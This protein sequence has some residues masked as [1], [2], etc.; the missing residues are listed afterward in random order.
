MPRALRRSKASPHAVETA[1]SDGRRTGTFWTAFFF[2]ALLSTLWS[3]ASPVFSV[4]DENA[5]VIKAVG[6]L[7]GELVGHFDPDARHPV[8]DLPAGWSVSPQIQCFVYHPEVPASCG[9][10]IGDPDGATSPA[11]W[12]ARYNPLYYYVIG[13]PSLFVD[14][15][16]GVYILRILSALFGSVF[17]AWAYQTAV[18][19]ARARWMPFAVAFAASP[20][21][22]YLLGSV[23]PNGVEIASAV[24]L[25]TALPRLLQTFHP[26]SPAV[27][28]PR[29]YLWV[30]VVVACAVLAN[31]RALGP[32]W[33]VVVVLLC[34]LASGWSS[35]RGLFTNRRSYLWLTVIAVTGLFSV[36]WTLGGGS[37]SGQA[38]KADAPLVGA[39][40]PTGFV[41]MLR[42]T[43]PFLKQAVGYF[44]WFDASLPDVAFWPIVAAS[45]ILLVLAATASDRRS[46]LTLAAVSLSAILVPALVQAYGV[47]STGIIWQGRYGLFLYLGVAIVA[48]WLLSGPAG[49]RLA[50]LAP[51]VTWIGAGLILLYGAVAFALVLRRYVTGSEAL[52]SAMWNDPQW[53]PPLGW[54]AL[55]LLFGIVS[56][57][58]VLWVGLLGQSVARQEQS[59]A[60]EERAALAG[61]EK[62]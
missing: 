26:A 1:V 20:M 35:V 52:P 54:P 15:S 43:V 61:S 9:V 7:R 56:V 2:F 4:P 37:L 32:L 42:L 17:L 36:L 16:A 33:L 27:T 3:L 24:A 23:N 50:Y 19:G 12:V 44:G 34:F 48:G 31:A 29:W 5:H 39:S 18:A 13:W 49:D 57:G 40:F 11:S 8:F 45:A 58:F 51:R 47:A 25:W 46:V 38:E 53:Q 55:C 59:V 30:I 10:E 60:R 22:I 14:G 6:Q 41:Y 21:V 28:L 62:R